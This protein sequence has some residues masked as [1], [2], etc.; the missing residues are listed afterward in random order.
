MAEHQLIESYLAELAGRLPRDTVAELAEILQA[1][2]VAEVVVAE[3]LG[4][5]P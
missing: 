3:S 1:D 2:L 5:R 4:S